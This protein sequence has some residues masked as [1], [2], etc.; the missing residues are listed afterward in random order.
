M[1]IH[2]GQ[3]EETLNAAVAIERLRRYMRLK[4]EH[5]LTTYGD[6]VAR[7]PD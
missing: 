1:V 3:V 4:C 5:D 7:R 6:V 2:E